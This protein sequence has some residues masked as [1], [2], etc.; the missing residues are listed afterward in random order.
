MQHAEVFLL[1]SL[2][3]KKKK[4]RERKKKGLLL[5]NFECCWHVI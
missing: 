4:E 1:L 2:Y 3:V 5:V